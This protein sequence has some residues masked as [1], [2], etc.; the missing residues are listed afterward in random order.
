MRLRNKSLR[1]AF[2]VL[3]MVD[4]DYAFDKSKTGKNA[5]FPD[6][7]VNVDNDSTQKHIAERSGNSVTLGQWIKLRMFTNYSRH[8]FL[9]HALH[10]TSKRRTD[11]EQAGIATQPTFTVESKTI[12]FNCV[13][14]DNCGK[15]DQ[16][17]FIELCNYLGFKINAP[18]YAL[19]Q[20]IHMF[21][22]E[23]P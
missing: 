9:Q 7:N 19:T 5:I 17:Q 8:Y 10:M 6:E 11:K 20:L 23:A 3:S 22:E 4:D 1:R 2:S 14:D 15:I 18:T 12:L 16:R 21:A 13:D